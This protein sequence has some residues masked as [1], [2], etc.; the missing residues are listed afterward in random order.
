[1]FNTLKATDNA[2]NGPHAAM[3]AIRQ[4]GHNLLTLPLDQ[5]H[6]DLTD[7][8]TI[9]AYIECD[10]FFD[11]ITC[12]AELGEHPTVEREKLICNVCKFAIMRAKNS[13]I[14]IIKFYLSELGVML[15]LCNTSG[16]Y[17][18]YGYFYRNPASNVGH[19]HYYIMVDK[20]ENVGFN[21]NILKRPFIT[22]Y[23]I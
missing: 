10:I 14:V 4:H 9:D 6:D 17:F 1:M 11:I 13:S 16:Y 23:S 20:N 22:R 7:E 5:G 8:S 21:T 2:R 18:R 15:F 19:E 3:N 12:D